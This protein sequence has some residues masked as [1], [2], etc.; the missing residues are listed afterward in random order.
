MRWRQI[1]REPLLHFLLAGGVLFGIFTLARPASNDLP[2]DKTITVDKERLL[3]F[4]QYRS[5]AFETEYFTQQLEAMSPEERN[6]LV[7]QYIEEEMLYREA[8]ALGLE[9][10]DYVIRQRLVQKMRFLI[11]DLTEG[12]VAPDDAVLREYLLKNKD[13]YML[14]PS[15]TFTHVFVDSAVRG[16]AAARQMAERLKNELNSRGAGFND[17][18]RFGDRFPFHENYVERT[19][20]YVQSQLGADFVAELT[21]IVPSDKQWNGPMRSMHGYHIV[22]LTSRTEARLPDLIEIR[23]QVAEDWER[24]RTQNARTQGLKRLASEY[25]IE[26]KDLA[27]ES[28]K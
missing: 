24:D 9:Q 28:A 18:P 12:G 5:K 21:K 7:N 27:A 23:A 25:T 14:E 1:L 8:K 4:L 19:L 16:N 13:I 26:R 20:D 11:D 3:T 22:L 17:S 6:S 15:L 2:S 10:G